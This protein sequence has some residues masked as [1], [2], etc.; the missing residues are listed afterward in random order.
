M[1]SN[2]SNIKTNV[3]GNEIN[4]TKRNTSKNNT[5]RLTITKG[6]AANTNKGG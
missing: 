5:Y 6:S 2:I 1:S 4:F 3:H